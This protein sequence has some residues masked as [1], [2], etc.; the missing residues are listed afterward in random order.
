MEL[1]FWH[2]R[3]REGQIGFHQETINAHLR[4]FWPGLG[5]PPDA[6][7]FVPLCGKSLDMLWLRA[8]GHR[9]I[10]VEISEIAVKS[11]FSANRLQPSVAHEPPFTKYTADGITI[12]CGDFFALAAAHLA[13]VG[14]MYD[15]ASLIALPPAMRERYAAAIAEKL[16]PA[17]RV[18]M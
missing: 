16:P 18:A 1:E 13:P 7:V 10:G 17:A 3:W 14:A 11:F 15:R 2:Q 6:A 9:V 8:Q 5:A 4:T 12:Y